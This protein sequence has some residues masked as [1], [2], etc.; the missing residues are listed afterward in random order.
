MSAGTGVMHSEFNHSDDDGVHFLQIW[1]MPNRRGTKPGYQQQPFPYEARRG[2]WRL[3]VSPDGQHDSLQIKQDAR[4]WGTMLEVDEQV[5]FDLDEGRGAWLHVVKGEVDAGGE[6]LK[7][8]DAMA[9][10]D[11]PRIVVTAAAKSELLLFDLA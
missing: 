1:I 3:L 10:E 6:R 9:V 7:R 8:G 11:V 2:Q 4:L 5:S